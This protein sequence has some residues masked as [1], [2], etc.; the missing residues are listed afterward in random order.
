MSFITEKLQKLSDF[1]QKRIIGIKTS[2]FIIL[3]DITWE[4]FQASFSIVTRAF[5]S[6]Q[7][8]FQRVNMHLVSFIR[9]K[10]NVH[11]YKILE[12]QYWIWVQIKHSLPFHVPHP[13]EDKN[14]S[15]RTS[16]GISKLWS[17][18]SRNDFS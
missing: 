16:F 3:I 12:Q 11:K 5:V 10:L 9:R 15:T 2:E 18:K 8:A 14:P 4:I 7:Q 6:G 17:P 1:F 13:G